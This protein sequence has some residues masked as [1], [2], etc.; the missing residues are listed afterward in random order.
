MENIKF[1][2]QTA[3]ALIVI[4]IVG[5]SGALYF[6]LKMAENKV[7]KMYGSNSA[8]VATDPNTNTGGDVDPATGQRRAY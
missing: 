6:S 1:N 5:V 7:S 8:P 3:L 4:V 2:W